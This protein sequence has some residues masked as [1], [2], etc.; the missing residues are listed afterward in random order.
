MPY[1]YLINE[2]GTDNYKI[3]LTRNET[4]KRKSQLQTGNSNQLDVI[5][6]FKTKYPFKLEKLLHIHYANKRGIGEWFLLDPKDVFSFISVCEN[7]TKT[8]EYLNEYNEF[9]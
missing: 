8:I 9:Y 2:S 4:K 1:I 5:K 7:F 3:G 6:S